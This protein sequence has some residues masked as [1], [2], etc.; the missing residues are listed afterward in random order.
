MAGAISEKV[1]VA[2][3]FLLQTDPFPNRTP[4]WPPVWACVRFS[5]PEQGN[6]P[7][8]LYQPPLGRFCGAFGKVRFFEVSVGHPGK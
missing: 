6:N 1:L 5:Q 8:L 4:A 7:L 2:P 3:V